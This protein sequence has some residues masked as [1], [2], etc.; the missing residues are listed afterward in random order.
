MFKITPNPPEAD[1]TS[2]SA[3]SKA[4]QQD[5]ITQRV[6]DPKTTPNRGSYSPS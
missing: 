3:K 1:S 5:E 2:T 4:K 6:L